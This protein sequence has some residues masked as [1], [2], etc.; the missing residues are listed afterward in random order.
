MKVGEVLTLIATCLDNCRTRL[1]H[2][3]YKWQLKD[4]GTNAGELFSEIYIP[5]RYTHKGKPVEL[6]FRD[7]FYDYSCHIQILVII[8]Q[9]GKK[10]KTRSYTADAVWYRQPS[11][12]PT[13]TV[14][15]NLNKLRVEK[16]S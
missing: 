9:L 14:L 15:L 5:P 16:V 11:G 6:S 7:I 12:Q 3:K 10:L 2:A 1:G 8:S 13:N 4:E